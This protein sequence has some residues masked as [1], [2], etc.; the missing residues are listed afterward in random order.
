MRK[1]MTTTLEIQ[2]TFNDAVYPAVSRALGRFASARHRADHIKNIL[3]AHFLSL[4]EAPGRPE[5]PDLQQSTHR[6]T[7]PR[8]SADEESAADIPVD[9]ENTFSSY[10]K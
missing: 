7:S 10:F 6:A 9:L 3:E 8:P 2:L 4:E 1:I 5:P